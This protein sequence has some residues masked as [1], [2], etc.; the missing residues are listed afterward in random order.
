MK[1]S[2]A[3]I[4][5]PAA[6]LLMVTVG[7][8]YFS[9]RIEPFPFRCSTFTHYDLSRNEGSRI[10]FQLTQDLRF[11]SKNS[12]YLLLNGQAVADSKTTIVNR[13]IVL[14]RGEKVDYD[15]YRYAINDIVSAST[16][17]TPDA[18][19]TLLLAEL[20]LD[21]S[22]LQFDVDKIDARSYLIG[23]PLSYLF[24]CQRY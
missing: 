15:T 14:S 8:D 16:D 23:G 10:E 20:T 13:R 7:F 17:T 12:G 19:F 3:F 6:L 18:V 4:L 9:S 24:T 5:A 21:P 11:D 22:Y 2:I 1:R